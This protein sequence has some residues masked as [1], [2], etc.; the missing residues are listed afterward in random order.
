MP[1]S[2]SDKGQLGAVPSL[3]CSH[4]RALWKTLGCCLE[5]E[6]DCVSH[7][8]H[9]SPLSACPVTYFFPLSICVL[10]THGI[11]LPSHPEEDLSANTLE[12][13]SSYPV[14]RAAG[15]SRRGGKEVKTPLG[16]K[17]FSKLGLPHSWWTGYWV[18]YRDAWLPSIH[19]A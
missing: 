10:I 6:L 9:V 11:A 8:Q 15:G 5:E 2:S 14:L 1:C 19:L 13:C 7:P 16:K 12:P 3:P 18:S 4:H 17:K